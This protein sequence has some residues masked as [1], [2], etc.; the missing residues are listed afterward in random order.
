MLVVSGGE[1]RGMLMEELQIVRMM[2]KTVRREIGV[3]VFGRDAHKLRN[4]CQKVIQL[5]TLKPH[6]QW[7]I[8]EASR[9]SANVRNGAIHPTIAEFTLQLHGGRLEWFNNSYLQL[10][11]SCIRAPPQRRRSLGFHVWHDQ[12]DSVN[13][14]PPQ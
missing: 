6:Q 10:L 14:L 9:I 7:N 4:T 2:V 12:Q 11:P 3:R 1:M 5:G 8:L 13:L